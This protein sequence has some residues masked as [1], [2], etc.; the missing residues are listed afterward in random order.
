VGPGIKTGLSIKISNPSAVG[1]DR[2]VNAVAAKALFGT[3]ALVIDFGTGTTFDYI[4]EDG[5]YEGG[6][7]CPGPYIALDA[8]VRNTAKLPRI[9]FAWPKS[10]V[11]RDTIS[12]MQAGA[13]GGYGCMVDGIVDR[14]IS[15]LG[16]IEHIIA[17]GGFGRLFA[18]HSTRIK[19]YDPHLTL[20]GMRIL[21]DL[22]A[23]PP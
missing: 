17:T 22:N 6:V 16:P 11:G 10:F 19:S 9:E 15:E 7:I 3:P 14:L 20:K 1:A 2:V 23:T 12:A 5:S 8:L 21:A 18:A 4:G 13:I